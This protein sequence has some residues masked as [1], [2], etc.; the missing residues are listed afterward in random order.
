MNI[1]IL[2]ENPTKCAQYHVDR[3]VVKMITETAQILSTAYYYTNE[4]DRAPYKLTH[5]NHPSCKWARESLD[6]WLWLQNLGIEL[7]IEYQHRYGNKQHKSGEYILNM[8]PPNLEK[9]G[10]TKFPLAMPNEYKNDNPIRAYRNYYKYGKQ[11]LFKWKNR[12]KP[13]WIGEI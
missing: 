3:H 12:Q 13:E 8:T 4:E 10:M 1:F 11:H 2:D 6:N 7:Y 9:T 5:K